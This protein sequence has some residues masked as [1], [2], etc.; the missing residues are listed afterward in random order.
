MVPCCIGVRQSLPSAHIQIAEASW[1]ISGLPLQ[2]TQRL[3]C[4]SSLVLTYFLL[5]GYNM[6]PKKKLHFSLWVSQP[7]GTPWLVQY[8]DRVGREAR[9]SFLKRPHKQKD[10]TNDVHR[11]PKGG[12]SKT[13]PQNQSLSRA[14]Q[15]LFRA[16]DGY[17]AP[18]LRG[19]F[20]G[21][22]VL[23]SY[24]IWLLESTLSWS[25]LPCVLAPLWGPGSAEKTTHR[26]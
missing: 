18:T 25:F 12:P 6:L 9:S 15:G 7:C 5:R 2:P 21:P 4:S 16:I 17:Y 8:W 23:G 22:P 1:K 19:C 10:P 26:V 14:F 11:I 24:D 13:Y 3:Q 20:S